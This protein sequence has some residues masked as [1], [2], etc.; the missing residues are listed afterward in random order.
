MGPTHLKESSSRSVLILNQNTTNN[1]KKFREYLTTTPSSCPP[2]KQTSLSVT[3]QDSLNLMVA[4]L[5]ELQPLPSRVSSNRTPQHTNK[6]C[7]KRIIKLRQ[8]TVSCRPHNTPTVDSPLSTYVISPLRWQFLIEAD[9]HVLQS[10][11]NSLKNPPQPASLLHSADFFSNI[12]LC[13]FPA[14]IFLQRPDIVL[15]SGT[16]QK[17]LLFIVQRSRLFKT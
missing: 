12:L 1:S 17:F 15:V 7:K 5:L 10:I 14:E 3:E 8:I 16:R 4:D 2:W 9:R 6:T 13:D 11:E